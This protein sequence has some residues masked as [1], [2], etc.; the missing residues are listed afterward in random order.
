MIFLTIIE[1]FRGTKLSV[2][3]IRLFFVANWKIWYLLHIF[4]YYKYKLIEITF[5]V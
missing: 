4:V 3:A 1:G 2:T 5:V